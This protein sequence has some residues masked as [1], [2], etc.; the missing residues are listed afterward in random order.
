[1]VYAKIVLKK[2]VNLTTL[3]ELLI[4]VHPDK[5]K[6]ETTT[7]LW[8]KEPIDL[9][10]MLTP[11]KHGASFKADREVVWLCTSTS[12]EYTDEYDVYSFHSNDENIVMVEHRITSR[13]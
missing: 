6:W 2:V 11:V 7:I 12:D 8:E 10:Q 1:M 5:Q 3:P 4:V 13:K 9:Q